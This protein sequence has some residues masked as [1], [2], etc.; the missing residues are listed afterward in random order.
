[1]ATR[2]RFSSILFLFV[3]LIY[4]N[5]PL[6]PLFEYFIFKDYIAKNLCVER[7]VENNECQGCCHLKKQLEVANDTEK[8]SSE[9]PTTKKI[10]SEVKEIVQVLKIN[11]T[12]PKI[13]LN[14]SHY[15]TK[16]LERIILQMVFVPPK[17]S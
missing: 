8:S 12:I 13:D 4:I 10:S 11:I 7:E 3:L 16:K 1:M 2:A 17:Q 15:L 9:K 5:K 14:R 6:L